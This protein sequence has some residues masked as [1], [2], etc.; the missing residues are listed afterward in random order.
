MCADGDSFRLFLGDSLTNYERYY[1][2]LEET[3]LGPFLL[4]TDLR[5][6]LDYPATDGS[7]ILQQPEDLVMYYY[8]IANIEVVA[9]L[10]RSSRAVIFWTIMQEIILT[11]PCW[12]RPTRVMY[13]YLHGQ[14][15][16]REITKVS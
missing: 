8:A 12:Y 6:E 5:L 1:T 3:N 11:A 14:F 15:I 13:I 10:E 9:G 4:F 16:T 7:E 2:A